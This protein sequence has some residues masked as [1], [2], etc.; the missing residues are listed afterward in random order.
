MVLLCTLEEISNCAE[1][2]SPLMPTGTAG[3]SSMLT[4]TWVPQVEE[5]Y[6]L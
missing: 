1:L 3:A 4:Q 2:P 5:F 6:V